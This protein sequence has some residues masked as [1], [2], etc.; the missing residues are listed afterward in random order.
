LIFV[1]FQDCGDPE[2]LGNGTVDLSDGTTFGASALYKCNPG[3]TLH[4]DNSTTCQEDGTW[5][6]IEQ[7]CTLNS[8]NN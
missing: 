6:D 3:Y 2:P 4:G 5:H 7:N 1:L 8:K